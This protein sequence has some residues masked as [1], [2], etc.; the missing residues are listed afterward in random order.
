MYEIWLAMNIVWE[1]AL[2]VAPLLLAA[3][4]VW[5]LLL[6]LAWRRGGG[7]GRA[8]PGA[9]AAGVV[10][11]V[12]GLLLLPGWNKSAL[13]EMGYW[14]DWANLLAMAAGFGAVVAAF[15][16]P[17]LALRGPARHA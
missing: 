14:V 3:A 5:V 6:V 4:V 11:T 1:M 2:A 16:W 17:L 7:W 9:I 13:G 12:L 8:L 10:V 15:V